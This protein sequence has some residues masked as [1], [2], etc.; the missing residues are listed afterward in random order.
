MNGVAEVDPSPEKEL[1]DAERNDDSLLNEGENELIKNVDSETGLPKETIRGSESDDQLKINRG[2][3]FKNEALR[4]DF[5]E[6]GEN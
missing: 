3:H 1:V 6:S 5:Y 2:E 4:H